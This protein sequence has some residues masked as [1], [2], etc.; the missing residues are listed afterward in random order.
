MD[1]VSGLSE[2]EKD[3]MDYIVAKAQASI[4]KVRN[5]PFAR[6]TLNDKSGR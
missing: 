6:N 3:K 5:S 4:A 1:K 2:G